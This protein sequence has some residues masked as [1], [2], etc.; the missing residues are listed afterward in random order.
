MNNAVEQ[1][2]VRAAQ[3]LENQVIH[4]IFSYSMK[5]LKPKESCEFS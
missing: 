4:C 3:V 2:L 5:H 1:H